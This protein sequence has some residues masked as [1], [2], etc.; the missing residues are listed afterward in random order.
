MSWETWEQMVATTQYIAVLKWL[1][2]CEEDVL[3]HHTRQLWRVFQS[4]YSKIINDTLCAAEI[5]LC[6][7]NH[8][9]NSCLDVWYFCQGWGVTGVI[10]FS[11]VSIT[12]R[13]WDMGSIWCW[14][15]SWSSAWLAGLCPTL[16]ASTSLRDQR[17]G[18]QWQRLVCPRRISGSALLHLICTVC[19]STTVKLLPDRNKAP[20]NQ[21]DY[22]FGRQ[23]KTS[24]YRCWRSNS[25]VN[26]V[27][28]IMTCIFL[29]LEM[30]SQHQYIP[31]S[32]TYAL[33]GLITS[34]PLFSTFRC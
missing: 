6:W 10:G 7:T 20:D 15:A 9:V 30:H 1:Q 28:Q 27:I 26:N 32:H 22:Y 19:C 14:K 33:F 23:V 31:G 17:L 34:S 18:R 24:C 2:S 8:K 21:T 16:P 5:C 13:P 25:R 4:P 12:D 11:A 3:F 29:D